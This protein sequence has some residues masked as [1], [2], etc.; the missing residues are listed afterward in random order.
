MSNARSVSS[1]KILKVFIEQVIIF[2]DEL[3]VTFPKET[4]LVLLRIFIKLKYPPADLMESLILYV[5]PHKEKIKRR[6]ESYFLEEESL[7]SD[8]KNC[9]YGYAVVNFKDIWKS[10]K[11]GVSDRDTIWKWF[12]AFVN[13]G[14]RY[15]ESV[16]SH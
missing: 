3:I 16:K 11:L 12:D 6:D 14:E 15:K 13:L 10:S 4:D 5:L 1:D 8:A 7:F 2:L 9:G